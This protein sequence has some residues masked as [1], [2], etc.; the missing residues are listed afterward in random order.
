LL[1]SLALTYEERF[2]VLYNRF[3][4]DGNRDESSHD[5]QRNRV[6]HVSRVGFRYPYTH[7]SE[8]GLERRSR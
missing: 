2:R 8:R 7:L 5:H 3:F 4:E 6:I 1:L